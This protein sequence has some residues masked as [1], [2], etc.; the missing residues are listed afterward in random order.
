MEH[1][2]RLGLVVTLASLKINW[3]R[4]LERWAVP[5][6][7][8]GRPEVLLATGKCWPDIPVGPDGRPR[9]MVIVNYDRLERHAAA[10]RAQAWDLVVY[11]ECHVMKSAVTLRTVYGLGGIRKTK[12]PEGARRRWVHTAIPPIPLAEGGQRVFLTGTPA[13]NRPIELWPILHAIDPLNFGD[14]RRFVDR[15]C[16]ARQSPK[17]PAA[18]ATAASE[19]SRSGTCPARATWPSCSGGCAAAS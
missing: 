17:F 11:D 12:A 8:G 7:D 18:T 3:Q 4:E 19:P 15:Y 14:W 5:K 9:G 6:D 16:A 2:A 13:L 10:I 1:D